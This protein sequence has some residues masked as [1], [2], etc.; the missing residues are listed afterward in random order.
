MSFENK[1]EMKWVNTTKANLK[2][3]IL[4]IYSVFKSNYLQFYLD[5]FSFKLN[6]RKTP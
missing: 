6:K 1:F 2:R 5:E 4:G 3:F